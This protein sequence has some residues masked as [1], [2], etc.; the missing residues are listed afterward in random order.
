MVDNSTLIV[1][2]KHVFISQGGYQSLIK[3]ETNKGGSLF[4]VKL[5]LVLLL[6]V[7]LVILIKD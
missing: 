1:G 2:G 7:S 4:G 5:I 6:L 3:R